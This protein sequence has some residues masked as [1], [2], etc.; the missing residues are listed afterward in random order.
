[1]KVKTLAG[2][3]K[4]ES[5]YCLYDSVGEGGEVKGQWLGTHAAAFPLSGFPYL[6]EEHLIPLFDITEKQRESSFFHHEPL[7]MGYNFGDADAEEIMLDRE[8]ATLGYNGRIIRPIF[9]SGG[10]EFIDVDYL[11]PLADAADLLELYERHTATGG[12]YFAAKVGLMI[13]GIIMPLN[14]IEEGLVEYMESLALKCRD[15]LALKRENEER[16][17]A[18][19]TNQTELAEGEGEPKK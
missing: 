12:T 10:L 2:I 6:T 9:T 1:M 14:I 16:R 17:R 13:V 11:T 5:V 3:C 18:E 4:R 19:D 7:P 15:A 8:K